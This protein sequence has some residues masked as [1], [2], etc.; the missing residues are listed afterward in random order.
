MFGKFDEQKHLE[1]IGKTLGL[2]MEDFNIIVQYP[3]CIT[4]V[5]YETD[6]TSGKRVF[7]DNQNKFIRLTINYI[8]PNKKIK[9]AKREMLNS[10]E[11]ELYEELEKIKKEKLN[12][13]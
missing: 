8:D 2:A 5:N 4:S 10:A 9:N 13:E 6:E 11:K 1:E 3:E 12:Y 7:D